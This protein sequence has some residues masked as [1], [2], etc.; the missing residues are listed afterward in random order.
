MWV[1]NYQPLS[2]LNISDGNNPNCR[3]DK[4]SETISTFIWDAEGRSEITKKKGVKSDSTRISGRGP[5]GLHQYRRS[6]NMN[7]ILQ[8]CAII[9]L[10]FLKQRHI[11]PIIVRVSASKTTISICRH[12]LWT[13]RNREIITG[14]RR[15]EP[16]HDNKTYKLTF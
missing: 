14:T 10:P 13:G 15:K 16:S 5:R 7:S 8:Y 4:E 6:R 9:T 2:L 1:H 11:I 12:P 3:P